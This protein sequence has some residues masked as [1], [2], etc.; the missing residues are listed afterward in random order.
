MACRGQAFEDGDGGRGGEPPATP[1][2]ELFRTGQLVA[3]TIIALDAA[4]PDAG[5]LKTLVLTIHEVWRWHDINSLGSL[6][7]TLFD[8]LTHQAFVTT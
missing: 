8:D 2:T 1:L 4:S 7:S 3:A 5:L 6:G